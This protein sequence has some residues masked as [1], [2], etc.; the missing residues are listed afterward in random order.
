[1]RFGDDGRECATVVRCV[2][3]GDDDDDDDDD[4]VCDDG[5]RR[6]GRTTRG[7]RA[8]EGERG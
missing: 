3:A 5:F 4:D 2:D 6:E 1:M 7:R 8:V